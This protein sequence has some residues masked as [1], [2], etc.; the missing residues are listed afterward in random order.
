LVLLAVVTFTSGAI[1]ATAGKGVKTPL[2]P[3]T[4]DTPVD[5]TLRA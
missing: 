4:G 3:L 2:P 5:T 1:L